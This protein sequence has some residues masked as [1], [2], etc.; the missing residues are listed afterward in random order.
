MFYSGILDIKILPGNLSGSVSPS[1]F[2]ITFTYW[3]II[4]QGG[5]SSFFILIKN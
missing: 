2:D 1:L 3:Q 4:D 5:G